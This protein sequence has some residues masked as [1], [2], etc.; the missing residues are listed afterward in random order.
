MT[1]IETHLDRLQSIV[2]D[3]QNGNVNGPTIRAMQ[4]FISSGSMSERESNDYS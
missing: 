2:Y 3:E 1:D 4:N